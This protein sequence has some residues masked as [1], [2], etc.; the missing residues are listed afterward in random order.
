MRSIVA[1]VA[2]LA[3]AA[4]VGAGSAAAEPLNMTEFWAGT[5]AV[6]SSGAKAGAGFD[7]VLVRGRAP[8]RVLPA[9]MEHARR[10]PQSFPATPQCGH[11]RLD[12]PLRDPRR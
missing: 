12:A 8:L 5:W 4:A 10:G 2:S 6:Y 1:A 9:S 3:F 7:R 11:C